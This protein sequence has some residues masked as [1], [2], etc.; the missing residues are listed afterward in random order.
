LTSDT[1]LVTGI[2]LGLYT[3]QTAASRPIPRRG[4]VRANG[5]RV[6]FTP[7]TPISNTLREDTLL[8]D[9]RFLDY[10]NEDL[11]RAHK[12]MLLNALLYEQVGAISQSDLNDPLSNINRFNGW[13]YWAGLN[14][15]T[16]GFDGIGTLDALTFRALMNWFNAYAGVGSKDKPM[17]YICG[18]TAYSAL[19]PFLKA[20]GGLV[21][22]DGGHVREVVGGRVTEY[23]NEFGKK[24]MICVDPY[25]QLIN[26]GGDIF[27]CQDGN[28]NFY[29]GK[30]EFLTP[31]NP[32]IAPD[33]IL[34]G[35]ARFCTWIPN[36]TVKDNQKSDIMISYFS[37][38]P[39]Y[40]ELIAYASGI[41]AS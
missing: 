15:N 21:T 38:L 8:F 17:V 39:A 32:A 1:L 41:T 24:V 13:T 14:P 2:P 27:M 22:M 11:K 3:P 28:L 6:M 37:I 18:A 25:L 16:T 4:S 30:D 12:S 7:G 5:F 26:R 19:Q 33:G 20:E 9:G 29:V 23:I 34:P 36:Y 10:I 35:D 31:E 40:I